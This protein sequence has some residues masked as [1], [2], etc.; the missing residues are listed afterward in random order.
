[1][2]TKNLPPKKETSTKNGARKIIIVD[3]HPVMREGLAQLIEHEKDL[4][5]VGQFEEANKAFE[6]VGRLKPDVAVVDL[7]LKG[8]SGLEL[9][10]DIKANHPKLLVLVLSMYDEMLYAERVLR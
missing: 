6:G 3:D 2:K 7:S 5:I 8:S 4:V 9:I 10:K 1:M